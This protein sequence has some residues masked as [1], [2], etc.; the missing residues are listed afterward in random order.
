MRDGDENL[1]KGSPS[2]DPLAMTTTGCCV[3][4]A[5][6][7]RKLLEVA[8]V[9]GERAMLCGS[10]ALMHRRSKMQA[11]SVLELRELLRDKRGGS[12]RRGD[13]TDALGA[14]LS[15]AFAGERRALDRRGA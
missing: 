11:R 9:S 1:A 7:K 10:H 3:C 6:D 14:A 2:G 4:E 12:D 15:A 5:N 8:L 13:S